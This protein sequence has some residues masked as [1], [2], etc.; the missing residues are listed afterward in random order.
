M[1]CQGG[2]PK[3]SLSSPAL[4]Q[5][6]FF[7]PK[8]KQ[9]DLLEFYEYMNP[10]ESVGWPISMMFPFVDVEKVKQHTNRKIAWI[11]GQND[12]I[13]SPKIMKDAAEKYHAPLTIVPSAGEL[14][15][16]YHRV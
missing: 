13:M 9:E 3:S 6:V 4:V 14:N 1:I 10:E 16:R 5:K 11:G 12:V 8:M 2:D 15:C 7:G